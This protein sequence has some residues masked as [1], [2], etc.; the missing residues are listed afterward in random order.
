MAIV[1]LDAHV[2]AWA[3][4]SF[5]F[6]FPDVDVLK[7]QEIIYDAVKFNSEISYDLVSFEPNE[8]MDTID[9]IEQSNKTSEMQPMQITRSETVSNSYT[10]SAEHGFSVGV[11]VSASF[12]V[13]FVGGL[14]TTVETQYSYNTTESKTETKSRTWQFQQTVNVPSNSKITALIMLQKTQPKIPFT[15]TVSMQGF[16]TVY[17]V[18]KSKKDGKYY[19]FP[20]V[21]QQGIA[22]IFSQ[23]PLANYSVSGRVVY[24]QTSGV[25]EASEGL[26]AII[27]ITESPISALETYSE[28]SSKFNEQPTKSWTIPANPE[29]DLILEGIFRA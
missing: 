28:D 5:K 16:I 6:Y 25:F 9:Q 19:S 15:L 23:K 27:D 24:F 22:G 18:Y 14:D 2:G 29:K 17:V 12:K 10:W 26:K 7:V 8:Q 1:D 20:V 13:P 11:S 4:D 3:M 21:P